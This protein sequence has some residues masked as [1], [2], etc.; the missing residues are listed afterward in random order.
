MQIQKGIYKSEFYFSHNPIRGEFQANYHSSTP[1]FLCRPL[2]K[3]ADCYSPGF[4]TV[5]SDVHHPVR[6]VLYA[7]IRTFFGFSCERR[8]F[9]TT[10]A[11]GEVE[12]PVLDVLLTALP[13]STADTA[14]SSHL[15]KLNARATRPHLPR[16]GSECNVGGL[17][18]NCLCSV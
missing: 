13:C 5:C 12:R 18:C 7:A 11:S 8:D 9:A 3:S 6:G 14:P 15:A 1:S 16:A 17:C 4:C 10:R 2:R